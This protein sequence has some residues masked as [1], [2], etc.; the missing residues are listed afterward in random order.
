MWSGQTFDVFLQQNLFTPLGSEP[1][2][3]PPIN[4]ISNS[5]SSGPNLCYNFS[6]LIDYIHWLSITAGY[7]FLWQTL[8]DFQCNVHH[9]QSRIHHFE[10]T[11]PSFLPFDWRSTVEFALKMMDFALKM[12]DFVL[13]M[14]DFVLKMMDCCHSVDAPQWSMLASR[15][16]HQKSNG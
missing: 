5:N 10:L 16:H 3:P 13:N 12:M 6:I 4:T 2:W 1:L 9:F 8:H 7:N 11:D 15:S 14:M